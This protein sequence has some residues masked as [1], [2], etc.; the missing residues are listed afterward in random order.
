MV[1]D[2]VVRARSVENASSRSQPLR[3]ALAGSAGAHAD[4][5]EDHVVRRDVDAA[6]NQRDAGRRRGLAGDGQER[7]A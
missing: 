6:A 5:L 2:H 4:V 3:F 7:L 1:D